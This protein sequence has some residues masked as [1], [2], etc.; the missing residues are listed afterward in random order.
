MSTP[1]GAISSGSTDGA[2]ADARFFLPQGLVADATSAYVADTNNHTIRRVDLATGAVTTIAG[3]AGQAAY[4]DGTGGDARFNTPLGVALAADGHTLYV[5]DA[6]NRSIRAVDV[7][8]GAVTT[9][10]TNGAPG[11]MF[12]RFNTPSGLARAGNVLYVSDSADHVVVAIDLGT[13][14]VTS[15]AGTP[16]VAGA[17]DGTGM[18]AR[19]N[20]PAGLAAD[21]RGTLYVADTLN[22]AVRAIDLKSGAVTT[23]AGV[24]G[25]QGA[26]DG[27]AAMAHFAQPSALAVDAVGDLFVGDALNET[28]RRID[29]K[30]ATVSTPIGVI[31]KTGVQL[32]PLPAQIGQPTALAL[33][34][35]AKLL[36]FSE[37]SLLEAH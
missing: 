11:S 36:L 5:A 31:K 4:A 22:D 8:T 19:F 30:S 35:D 29:V 6:A 13:N 21:G 37:S 25:I 20:A 3:A 27:P 10:P 33:T 12:A 1:W 2:A 16:R 18:K 15:V 17:V 7:Q 14:L 23:L 24:L 26:D 28:V 32:G 9:L 34:P